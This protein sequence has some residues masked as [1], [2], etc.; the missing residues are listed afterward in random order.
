MQSRGGCEAGGRGCCSGWGL[1]QLLHPGGGGAGVLGYWEGQRGGTGSG[2]PV[3]ET[4]E[5]FHPE[6]PKLLGP[7]FPGSV[8][9]GEKSPPAHAQTRACL[10]D[11]PVWL[12]RREA[13]C[14]ATP[15]GQPCRCA[16]GRGQSAPLTP[17]CGPQVLA[18]AVARLVQDKFGDLTDNFSSPHA[19]RKVLAG[20]V[21]TTGKTLCCASR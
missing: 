20:V 19:R 5:E 7:V 8:L 2:L 16:R 9:E 4:L 10:P 14:K 18:D 6:P 21:M 3:R 12:S 1:P 15:K 11:L 17:C 13:V